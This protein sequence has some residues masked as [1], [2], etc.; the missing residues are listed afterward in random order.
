MFYDYI[1]DTKQKTS[2]LIQEFAPGKTLLK[3]LQD[4]DTE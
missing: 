2:Y 3:Y 4:A 1:V